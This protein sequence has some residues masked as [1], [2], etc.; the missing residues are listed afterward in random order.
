[1]IKRLWFGSPL[2]GRQWGETIKALILMT[3]NFLMVQKL[4]TIP[5]F[6]KMG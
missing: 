1:M 3:F 4:L 5:P 6:S 2:Q